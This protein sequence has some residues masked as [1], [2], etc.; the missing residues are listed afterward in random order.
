M[1]Q[2]RIFL[3]NAVPVSD[4]P[5]F[6][7]HLYTYLHN[8]PFPSHYRY[9]LPIG[10]DTLDEIITIVNERLCLGSSP[11]LVFGQ[12]HVPGRFN[13]SDPGSNDTGAG[14]GASS[15]DAH[16][17]ARAPEY[18]E[19][20]RGRAC[21][22][23]FKKGEAI[24]RCRN[25]GLDETCV[26]C[27]YCF[28]GSDHEGHDTSFSIA[29]GHG[30]CCD[31]NDPEAWKVPV[32][33]K[34]HTSHAK[35]EPSSTTAESAGA[36][37]G[38]SSSALPQVLQNSIRTTI[39]T[40]LDFVIDTIS[41]SPSKLPKPSRGDGST[42]ICLDAPEDHELGFASSDP[43]ATLKYNHACI[44]WNDETHSFTEVI[45]QVKDAMGVTTNEA[46][47]VAETVDSHGR[48][49]LT[50]SNNSDELS[51]VMSVIS[52]IGLTVSLRSARETFREEVS[53]FLI[54]WLK[55]LPRQTNGTQSGLSEPVDAFIRRVIC[56]ELCSSRRSFKR[57]FAKNSLLAGDSH[58]SGVVF[59]ESSGDLHIERGISDSTSDRLSKAPIHE[60]VARETRSR[61]DH[62]LVSDIKLWKGA[63][64]TMRELYIGT[65]IVSGDTTRK[66]FGIQ[67][68]RSYLPIITNYLFH[69]REPDLSVLNI[70]V[71][72]FTV[73]TI[74]HYLTTHTDLLT[75]IF[76]VL[77]AF[78]LSEVLPER[79]PLREIQTA[80][81]TARDWSQ[82]RY[83]PLTCDSEATKNKPYIH[84]FQ[85]AKYLL[86]ADKLVPGA[87]GV[88]KA[89]FT[90]FLDL[91]CVWQ[92]MHAQTRYRRQHIEY[93]RDQWIRAFNLSLHIGRLVQSMAE[94]LSVIGLSDLFERVVETLRLL[95]SWCHAV[96]EE[97]VHRVLLQQGQATGVGVDM[98]R[99]IP[100]ADGFHAVNFVPERPIRVPFFSVASQPVSFHHPL[101]WFLAHMLGLIVKVSSSGRSDADA[102][103]QRVFQEGQAPGTYS[104]A[105]SI[106]FV[107]R[108]ME[109]PLQTCVLLS[110]IR[111]G[112]WVRNGMTIRAQAS[113][114][115]STTFCD[116]HDQDLFLLQIYSAVVGPDI[117]LTALLDRYD[118]SLWFTGDPRACSSATGHE[119]QQIVLLVEDFLELLITLFSER[120]KLLQFDDRA[121]LRREMVHHLAAAG[122][123]GV[124][125]SELS[126]RIPERLV[127]T[128]DDFDDILGTVAEYK[129]P[130][131]PS[132]SGVY[133]LKNTEWDAVNPWFWHFSKNQREEV[134]EKLKTRYV[135]RGETDWWIPSLPTSTQGGTAALEDKLNAMVRSDTLIHLLYFSFWNI[136]FGIVPSTTII[137]EA[138][139]LLALFLYSPSGH[140]FATSLANVVVQVPTGLPDNGP[141]RE[142]LLDLLIRIIGSSQAEADD[143]MKDLLKRIERLV[144]RIEEIGDDH[145][146]FIVRRWR[147]ETNGHS[148]NAE[149]S[150]SEKKK[151]DAK[152]AAKARKAA[153]M[154]QFAAAQEKFVQENQM[155]VVEDEED[156]DAALNAGE[157]WDIEGDEMEGVETSSPLAHKRMW[158]YPSGTCIFCQ[159]ETKDKNETYGMLCFAQP[160][161]LLSRV[162]L[163]YERPPTIAALGLYISTCGHLM[164]LTCFHQY[165]ASVRNRQD[166]QLGRNQ[167]EDLERN[168]F[169]C[170]LCKT[171]GNVFVPVLWAQMEEKV[172]PNIT[173]AEGPSFGYWWHSGLSEFARALV[174]GELIE[175]EGE[176]V[177]RFEHV[178]Q[179]RREA[180]QQSDPSHLY[181]RFNRTLLSASGNQTRDLHMEGWV[182]RWKAVAY[183]IRC[184]EVAAR[185]KGAIQN[186]KSVIDQIPENGLTLL[187]VLC[188]GL[189]ASTA[190]ELRNPESEGMLEEW[191]QE[192]TWGMFCGLLEGE[193]VTNEMT[194][195]LMMHGVDALCEVFFGIGVVKGGEDSFWEWLSVFYIREIVATLI[196]VLEAVGFNKYKVGERRPNDEPH[197]PEWAAFFRAVASMLL[198]DDRE[199]LAQ[200]VL[201]TVGTTYLKTLMRKTMHGFLR[202]CTVLGWARFGIVPVTAGPSSDGQDIDIDQE[203]EQLRRHLR[204]PTLDA[205]CSSSSLNDQHISKL[206]NG[207]C[208]QLYDFNPV[209]FSSHGRIAVPGSF[210]SG[211]SLSNSSMQARRRSS[212]MS[213]RQPSPTVLLYTV[214][215]PA[216]TPTL[217]ALPQRLDTL[218]EE[219]TRRACQK[220]KQVPADPAICLFCGTL[221]CSQSYCCEEDD[222]GECNTHARSCGADVGI[223]I[224]IR[225]G[226][227]L[228]LHNDNG[229]FIHP[230]YLDSH[231]E[232]DPGLRRGRPLFLNQKRFDELA[233]MWTTHGIPS[234]V[235]RTIEQT[236]DR[237]GWIT[238]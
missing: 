208:R 18:Q 39:A 14:Q 160:S 77:K 115:R 22:H 111:A 164:H 221:V 34:Y 1:R 17:A 96:L 227:I 50:V 5:H 146:K 202:G 173:D 188:E 196:G 91:C 192:L 43:E 238:L 19:S 79:F 133:V 97:S 44:L 210:A 116:H 135:A 23:V 8:S 183:T 74:G 69:D 106:E 10:R 20:H 94:G 33:C 73:P 200:S 56:E 223:F 217:F 57:D 203:Y 36:T 236:F 166:T 180:T 101:H 189:M 92:G 6:D 3:P 234:Y 41:D 165:Y 129:S 102:L 46:K 159:E 60:G 86:S 120:S 28:H 90:R 214:V 161:T 237:G 63:R 48:H 199:N 219:S 30:G 216:R 83:P 53:G 65:F 47:I 229:C 32:K 156:D 151:L 55:N 45:D 195:F 149:Q 125:Y 178:G 27:S 78:F 176:I 168:E 190:V 11:E 105:A 220:C 152:A 167:P 122:S 37:A 119:D 72:I 145:A 193:V 117:F 93:E 215:T 58:M 138:V 84:L 31:C 118:L 114:Y 131:G 225:K 218:L 126:N 68:A 99:R 26:F 59:S 121:E 75:T 98:H 184:L 177:Q 153:I 141:D 12:R 148:N 209:H 13:E 142:T 88:D 213:A 67:F 66:S 112:I 130:E 80:F 235:E 179:P 51:R 134:E 113:Y 64:N 124:T 70:S 158:D 224:V 109:I 2:R 233:K 191:G 9:E 175:D 154:A 147:D 29:T 82:S 21:G 207:W 172:S 170:P 228:L 212:A 201:D 81:A 205:L 226:L 104:A 100:E 206:I 181:R 198:I 42:V 38:A 155:S 87:A 4:M 107:S 222:K 139:H 95:D 25:C 89:T 24:Y 157:G 140:E 76:T 204:L 103:L 163:D 108:L 61:L 128:A 162:E 186:G 197:D 169:L 49:V 230:P 54:E 231:G 15:A 7:S 136:V 150:E 194:P 144:P 174:H 85:D 35:S 110:Q 211:S 171:L 40:V 123:H 52:R 143:D 71:Q 185:S 137:A 232:V 187:R 127:D 182:E 16:P 62:M 132:D